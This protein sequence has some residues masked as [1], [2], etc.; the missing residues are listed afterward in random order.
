[1][2]DVREVAQPQV[3]RR[4]G[5]GRARRAGLAAALAAP[6][7]DERENSEESG[8]ERRSRSHAAQR[9]G[10]P[11]FVY[12]LSRECQRAAHASLSRVRSITTGG[13]VPAAI[14]ARVTCSSTALRFA[15]TATHTCWK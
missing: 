3:D 1:M 13:S 8:S 11:E 14:S 12:K 7:G 5:A 15:R 9:T 2:R 6:S 10:F 4:L